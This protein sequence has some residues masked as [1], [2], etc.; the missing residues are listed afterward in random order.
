MI[1]QWKK[2]KKKKRGDTLHR[3]RQPP[4]VPLFFPF[5]P[6]TSTLVALITHQ[7]AAVAVC[8]LSLSKR[9]LTD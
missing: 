7:L 8:G 2:K 5:L 9:W 3:M 6:L 1:A 4:F